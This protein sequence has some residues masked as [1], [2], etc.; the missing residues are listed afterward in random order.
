MVYHN[1]CVCECRRS[2]LVAVNFTHF[3]TKSVQIH[4]DYLNPTGFLTAMLMLEISFGDVRKK[5]IR[6]FFEGFVLI[7]HRVA[8]QA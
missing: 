8:F 5:F 6:T 3:P 4:S 7:L 1:L 2:L